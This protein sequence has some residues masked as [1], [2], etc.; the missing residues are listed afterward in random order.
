[1]PFNPQTEIKN[2]C[3]YICNSH[4]QVLRSDRKY[5]TKYWDYPAMACICHNLACTRKSSSYS[6]TPRQV[7][8]AP[9]LRQAL[10]RLGNIGGHINN[11]I[12]DFRYIIG[13]CAEQHSA[14]I[15]IKKYNEHDLINLRFSSAMRPRTKQIYQYCKNCKCLFPNL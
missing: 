3:K 1:M 9:L 8:W 2:Y 6:H 10:N 5:H 11:N 7:E 4:I 13:Q 14:N 12:G 15:Y